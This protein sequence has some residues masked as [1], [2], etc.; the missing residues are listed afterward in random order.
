MVVHLWQGL[1]RLDT[2]RGG[3][4]TQAVLLVLV[5]GYDDIQLWCRSQD[6]GG[7]LED[8]GRGW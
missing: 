2:A 7:L 1:D 5:P 8:W 6:W 3:Y 4:R